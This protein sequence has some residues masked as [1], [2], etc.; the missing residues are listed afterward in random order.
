MFF[1]VF[2]RKFTMDYDSSSRPNS[3]VKQQKIKDKRDMSKRVNL[4]KNRPTFKFQQQQQQ[5]VEEV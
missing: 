1:Y 3:T 2:F 4:S 5:H